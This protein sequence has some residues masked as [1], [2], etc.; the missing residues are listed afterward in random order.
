MLSEEGVSDK[1]IFS[2]LRCIKCKLN[3]SKYLDIINN[4]LICKKCSKKSKKFKVVGK[5]KVGSKEIDSLGKNIE[6]L[7]FKYFVVKQH[8]QNFVL[9]EQERIKSLKLKSENYSDFEWNFFPKKDNFG[10][11]NTFD[12]YYNGEYIST[13][14]NFG[15]SLRLLDDDLSC[16]YNNIGCNNSRGF[17]MNCNS[18]TYE[19]NENY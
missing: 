16:G 8:N 5:H 2:V 12:F 14:E 9:R 19:C 17:G 6:Q 15:Y 7:S 4:I 18:E 1:V 10:K 3:K 13:S 11:S